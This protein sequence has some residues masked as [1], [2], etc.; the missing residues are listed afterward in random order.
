MDDLERAHRRLGVRFSSSDEEVRAASPDQALILHGRAEGP[1]CVRGE[2]LHACTDSAKLRG[3][4]IKVAFRKAAFAAHPDRAQ[5]WSS[6]FRAQC[7]A[8]RCRRFLCLR[9]QSS[10]R[11]QRG[12]GDT[13]GRAEYESGTRVCCFRQVSEQASA[14]GFKEVQQAFDAI[15][16]YRE[17]RSLA[18][19]MAAAQN[20]TAH[21]D[22]AYKNNAARSAANAAG[23]AQVRRSRVAA[24]VIGSCLLMSGG[25]YLGL[26]PVFPVS[27]PPVVRAHTHTRTH[28]HAHAPHTH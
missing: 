5:V 8:A 11:A 25:L 26:R 17:N 2:K 10:T 21:R 9:P 20:T 4:Q 13:A 6:C 14:D 19:R 15:K 1:W 28:T 3:R 16:S 18:H 23:A 27:Q 24:T 7:A 12:G 22:D